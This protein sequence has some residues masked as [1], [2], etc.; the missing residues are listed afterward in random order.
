MS[1]TSFDAGRQV[2]WTYA[3]YC[4]LGMSPP[5]NPLGSPMGPF[6]LMVVM[7]ESRASS[8]C[9]NR[10]DWP[11]EKVT[12]SVGSLMNITPVL[13]SWRPVFQV[14][15]SR[16]WYFFWSVSCGVLGFEPTSTPLGK[17]S[18]GRSEL[19]PMWLWKYENWNRNS[20]SRPLLST[21]LRLA[22]AEWNVFLLEPQWS[23]GDGGLVP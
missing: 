14:K 10:G 6:W 7:G 13:S 9:T 21:E 18:V 22:I 11:E 3:P 12:S 2:S 8:R 17:R 15:S 20:F 23:G 1:S 5:L 19:A 4:L 16:N